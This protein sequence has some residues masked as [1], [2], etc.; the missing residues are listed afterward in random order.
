VV[1]LQEQYV[2]A[3]GSL[4][5]V[6]AVGALAFGGVGLSL[7]LSLVFVVVVIAEDFSRTATPQI[8]LC[9]RGIRSFDDMTRNLLDV[10]AIPLLHGLTHL[11]IVADPSH[12]TGRRALVMPTTLALFRNIIDGHTTADQSRR[13]IAIRC[14][15]R[16]SPASSSSASSWLGPEGTR[17]STGR[18]GRSTHRCW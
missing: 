16:P 17:S 11:P 15:R 4:A 1:A 5:Q 14:M 8:M 13:R 6:L 3:P 2:V 18:L 10:S 7:S 9:E 12:G